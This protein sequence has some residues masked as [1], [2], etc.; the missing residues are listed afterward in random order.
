MTFEPL[1]GNKSIEDAAIRYVMELER[2]AGREPVDRRHEASFAADISSP[3]RTI[4]VKAV[5]KDQRGWFVP[6]EARQHDAALADPQFYLYVVDNIRQADP[7]A[8]RLKVFAREQLQRL[9]QNAKKREYWEMPIPVAE[10]DSAP[11][12]E[13]VASTDQTPARKAADRETRLNEFT[14]AMLSIYRNAK[15]QAHY[16]AKIFLGMVI[17]R[18]GLETARYLVMSDRPSDGYTALYERQ[19][20]D[21]TVEALVIQPE[22]D[23]LFSEEERARAHQRLADYGFDVRAF[24][25]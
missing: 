8:F 22:W 7:S 20:L 15:S 17:D 10:F 13:S 24:L 3:P 14:Q 16:D 23:D 1:V 25:R 4:E 12:P 9:L 2:R 21:L 5:G 19:R 6:L 18:G 11:G